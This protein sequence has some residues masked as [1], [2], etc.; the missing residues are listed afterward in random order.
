MPKFSF[1]VTCY[2]YEKYLRQCIDSILAQE[3][4]DDYEI[5]CVD[6]GSADSTPKILSGYAKKDSRVKV[7]TREN[8][9]LEVACNTGIEVA[10]APYIIRVDADDFIKPNLLKVMYKAIADDPGYSFYYVR[11][12]T[13]FYDDG[14]AIDKTLPDFDKDEIFERGDFFATSTVYTKAHLEEMGLFPTEIPNCGL[15]NY[16]IILALI[17]AG[18]EGLPVSG[19]GFSYRRHRVN[20]SKVKRGKIIEYG[21]NLLGRYGKEFKTNQY[22]PYNLVL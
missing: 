11:E 13:E 2:N 19:S 6:D 20:M 15:E 18:Y 4:I 10:S 8:G 21:K 22:H 9:G 7:I 5:V 16:T 14:E 12:Y 3:E 1:I 17:A